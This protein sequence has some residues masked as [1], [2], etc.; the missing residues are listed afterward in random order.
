MGIPHPPRPL[1]GE[2][3]CNA[4][5][6]SRACTPH[7]AKRPHARPDPRLLP[8]TR[9]MDDPQNPT[10]NRFPLWLDRNLDPDGDTTAPA[11]AVTLTAGLG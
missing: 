8:P 7:P 11:G 1:S 9:A 3:L 10:G 5:A 6:V 2:R 4:A